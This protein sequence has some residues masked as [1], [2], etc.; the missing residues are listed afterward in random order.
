MKAGSITLADVAAKSQSLN[1]ACSRCERAG[2]YRL[3]SLIALHG[4]DFGIPILLDVLAADC[5]RLN[6][7][8]MYDRCGIHCADCPRFFLAAVMLFRGQTMVD[9][10]AIIG[11][12]DAR[13]SSTIHALTGVKRKEM[14]WMIRYTS[15]SKETSVFPRSLQEAK[16]LPADIV[17]EVGNAGVDCVIVALRDHRYPGALRYLNEFQQAGWNIAGHAVLA[18]GAQAPSL[19][20]FGGG[21]LIPNSGHT[22]ANA[23]A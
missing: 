14:K 22:P 4:A 10:W 18:L 3:D 11:G 1:I 7:V 21:I 19:P 23:I 9:V 17:A 2:R 5:P 13:K 15:G 6:S 8:S 12:P 16:V 20:G